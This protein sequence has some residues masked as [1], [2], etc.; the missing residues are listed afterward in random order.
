MNLSSVMNSPP[1]GKGGSVSSR[2][3]LLD[4]DDCACDYGTNCLFKRS[5]RLDQCDAR[6]DCECGNVF[7]AK[8][9]EASLRSEETQ[10]VAVD[11][12]KCNLCG[13]EQVCQDEVRV[14]LPEEDDLS[15]GVSQPAKLMNRGQ[16][17]PK[18]GQKYAFMQECVVVTAVEVSHKHYHGASMF[19]KGNKT[20]AITTIHRELVNG[21]HRD[22]FNHSKGSYSEKQVQGML[23]K[24][25]LSFLQ[26]GKLSAAG[27]GRRQSGR[28]EGNLTKFEQA[29][30]TLCQW[31]SEA[32]TASKSAQ[33]VKKNKEAAS[34]MQNA[35]KSKGRPPLPAK[36]ARDTERTA[37]SLHRGAKTSESTSKVGINFHDVSNERQKILKRQLSIHM[38]SVTAS[39]Q[40]E[41]QDM[42]DDEVELAVFLKNAT[43]LQR[44]LHSVG[45]LDDVTP[46]ETKYLETYVRTASQR[47]ESQKSAESEFQVFG[48]ADDS[49]VDDEQ[50][51]SGADDTDARMGKR[52]A[53][54]QDRG[55]GSRYGSIDTGFGTPVGGGG[56]ESSISNSVSGMA[57]ALG[58]LVQNMQ[59]FQSGF[60]EVTR[61][62]QDTAQKTMVSENAKREMDMLV[63]MRQVGAISEAEMKRDMQ[64]IMAKLHH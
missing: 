22:A 54:R 1:G 27:G 26:S 25:M 62:Q 35:C 63:T 47:G 45:M 57:G 30:E 23:E 38:T 24:A 6:K 44:M 3:Q 28:P 16:Q 55:K 42:A 49:E 51:Y 19:D 60:M 15:D 32:K 34:V 36:S 21:N 14:N 12:E 10:D 43:M 58:G 61:Q 11:L 20:G 29:C 41:H 17:L 9:V 53:K 33:D 48:V 37:K 4:D 40:K 50:Y 7:H 39:L 52:D 18:D 2:W 13:C 64:V 59:Q 5:T 46:R 8:C 31:E 56:V